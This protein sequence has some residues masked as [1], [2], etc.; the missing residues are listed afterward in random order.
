MPVSLAIFAAY[1]NPSTHWIAPTLAGLPFGVGLILTFV[2]VLSYLIDTFGIHCASALAANS[3]L[4]ALFGAAFPL[5]ATKM[6]HG[7]GVQWASGLLAFLAL[8]CAPMPFLFYRY[9][10]KIRSKSRFASARIEERAALN[11][12]SGPASD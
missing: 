11:P 7:L 8:L 4:R 9:G 6:Y 2:S 5:F 3:F 1:C 10:A 12:Q